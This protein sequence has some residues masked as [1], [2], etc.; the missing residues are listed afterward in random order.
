[1]VDRNITGWVFYLDSDAYIE[2]IDF[3]LSDYLKD[4]GQFAGIFSGYVNNVPHWVNSGGFAL[5]FSHTL[6]RRLATDYWSF[7]N[8]IPDEKYNKAKIWEKDIEDD[9]SMLNSLLNRYVEDEGIGYNFIFEREGD[10]VV[11]LGPFIWQ[12]IRAHAP[13]FR[14]RVSNLTETVA[15]ITKGREIAWPD[16]GP[17]YYFPTTHTSIKTSV[18]KKN[19]NG[20]RTT[21][22]DGALL[23]GPYIQLRE[24]DY[25]IRLFGKLLAEKDSSTSNFELSVTENSGGNLLHTSSHQDL[26]NNQGILAEAFFSISHE[27][28]DVEAVV[29]VNR[30]TNLEI[31]AVQF[32]KIITGAENFGIRKTEKELPHKIW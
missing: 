15:Q 27:C 17:G 10:S 3:D 6:G 25:C 11:N 2:N 9:Q 29:R 4:K 5:N 1:M 30:E 28:L 12:H 22:K 13:T 24:G 32:L 23:Y 8:N 26:R 18:G 21:G 7:V 14:D 20:V 16:D 31:Y 19:P